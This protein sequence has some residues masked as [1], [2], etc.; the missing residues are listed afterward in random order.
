MSIHKRQQT[1]IR[2]IE[3]D[4]T[5]TASMIGRPHLA[6]KVMEAMRAVPRHA[7]VPEDL[8]GAAYDNRPLPIGHGQTISQPYIVAL[9]TDLLETEPG[10]R[11]LEI[12]TGSGYQ[13]AILAELVSRVFSIETISHLG[14]QAATRLQRLGYD[15][16]ETRVG[17]GYHGWPEQAPFDG[18]I[19]TAA[20]GH[21][22]PPLLEQLRPGG[23]LVIPV[24]SMWA[25]ELVVVSKSEKGDID[26]RDILP[27]AFVPLVGDHHHQAGNAST[28]GPDE[29]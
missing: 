5:Y 8:Q 24:G 13:T 12:G 16:I 21:V 9:M 29:A 23:R 3:A 1:M 18:I 20:A 28:T 26:T 25:Q 6:D 17:D 14:E 19:V 7:F 11:V 2:A 27:V 15:N 10:H 4:V 22:P